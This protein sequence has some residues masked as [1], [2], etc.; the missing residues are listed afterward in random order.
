MKSLFLGS[1]IGLGFTQYI[2]DANHDTFYQF[3]LKPHVDFRRTIKVYHSH[4]KCLQPVD[5]VNYLKDSTLSFLHFFYYYGYEKG[6]LERKYK[7]E[8]CFNLIEN[9]EFVRETIDNF[10]YVVENI[11]KLAE[12]RDNDETVEGSS[13]HMAKLE[14]EMKERFKSADESNLENM[15]AIKSL[16]KDEFEMYQ[17]KNAV[18]NKEDYY[19]SLAP[20]FRLSKEVNKLRLIEMYQDT[21]R[22]YKN[23]LLGDDLSNR[24]T[25]MINKTN[26]FVNNKLFTREKEDRESLH[27][28][29]QRKIK[30]I[31]ELSKKYPTVKNIEKEIETLKSMFGDK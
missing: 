23:K 14:R 12:E 28:L 4:D 15:E 29:N 6:K 7:R 19:S 9:F 27:E 18:M 10:Q 11:N 5:Y 22:N 2:S 26:D 25:E 31:P 13:A 16:T 17:L 24:K 20:E 21:I 8:L 30:E 3:L 1:L